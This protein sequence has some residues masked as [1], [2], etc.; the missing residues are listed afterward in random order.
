MIVKFLKWRSK[1]GVICRWSYKI[2]CGNEFL[3]AFAKKYNER[4]V[5]NPTTI[6][7]L[8]RHDP[9]AYRQE[10]NE[11]QKLVIGWTGSHSTLKYLLD[12]KEILK[13]IESKFPR[14]QITVIAD[15]KP[16]IVL[17]NLRFIP[18]KEET[19][20]EDL[21]S[22]D[23]GIMPLPDEVWTR[24]KCGFKALQYL[25]LR[26]PA[27]CSPVGVNTKIIDNGRN[28]FLC[29]TSEEWELALA[30]LIND[31]KLRKEMGENGRIKVINNY[32]VLSNSETFL[33]LFA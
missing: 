5:I 11:K 2:S 7:T 22:F 33:K 23:I 15:R 26:I 17:N 24:G 10:E 28:G 27:I 30:T 6:D 4:V 8:T 21:M 32:S 9:D 29:T 16:G 1:V 3:A 25:A 13:R 18:W 20:I 14:V 12:V 19:E 31:A